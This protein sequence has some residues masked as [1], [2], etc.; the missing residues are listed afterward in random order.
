MAR[1]MDN[2]PYPFPFRGRV[3]AGGT[4]EN[5]AGCRAV[6]EQYVTAERGLPCLFRWTS[7]RSSGT[8]WLDAEVAGRALV[9]LRGA[10]AS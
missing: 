2:C 9:A 8:C 4:V 7:T 6:C 5:S 10:D 3:W 1:R